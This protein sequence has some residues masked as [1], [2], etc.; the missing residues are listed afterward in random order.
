MLGRSRDS[1]PAVTLATPAPEDHG[2]AT[3]TTLLTIVGDSAKVEGKFEIADSINIECAVGGELKVG[4]QLLVGE[5]GVVKA[6]VQTVD[7]IIKGVYEG[8]MVATGDV[9]ITATGRVTAN[10]ETDSLVIAKGGFFNGNVVK[11]NGREPKG[12]VYLV[13]DKRA[14]LLR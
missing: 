3:A 8:T 6:N 7:A 11:K 9:E 13:E 12:A 5:K 1:R 4:R 10:I 2:L 14:G